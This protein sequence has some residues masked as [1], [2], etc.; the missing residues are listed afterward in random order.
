M[1]SL[2]QEQLYD[3]SKVWEVKGE[4]KFKCRRAFNTTHRDA[5]PRKLR[6]PSKSR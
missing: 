3:K 5:Q 6:I 1:V 4:R 2:H